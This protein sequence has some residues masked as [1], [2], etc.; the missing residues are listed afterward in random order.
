[1]TSASHGHERLRRT[2]FC[3]LFIEIGGLKLGFATVA[4]MSSK[5]WPEKLSSDE[6]RTTQLTILYRS[7]CIFARFCIILH[8]KSQQPG[9][10]HAPQI[11]SL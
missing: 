9:G 3:M 8:L 2:T 10:R 6:K 4:S 11:P 7:Y 1:M 5:V